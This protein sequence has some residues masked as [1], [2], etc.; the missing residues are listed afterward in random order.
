MKK[1]TSGN[2]KTVAMFSPCSVASKFPL[3]SAISPVL[4][5][6]L[7]MPPLSST[8]RPTAVLVIDRTPFGLIFKTNVIVSVTPGSKTLEPGTNKAISL[9]PL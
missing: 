7:T 8:P 9:L 3:T 2:S 1:S 4:E 5:V 6:S